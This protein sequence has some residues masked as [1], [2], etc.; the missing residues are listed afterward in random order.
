MKT[1]RKFNSCLVILMLGAVVSGL[2][3]QIPGDPTAQPPREVPLP[4]SAAGI[5]PSPDAPVRPRP[6]ERG[7]IAPG[8]FDSDF[9]AAG[10]GSPADLQSAFLQIPEPVALGRWP[11]D[12][13]ANTGSPPGEQSLIRRELR[14]GELGP[15]TAAQVTGAPNTLTMGDFSTA[16]AAA[17]ADRNEEWL[18]VQFTLEADLDRVRVVQSFNP[19][20]ITKV[21]AERSDGQ[22]VVLEEVKTSPGG[23]IPATPEAV[24]KHVRHRKQAGHPDTP[25][26]PPVVVE[27]VPPAGTSLRTTSVRITIDERKVPGWNEIDAVEIVSR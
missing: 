7:L 5:V 1:D 10:A 22:Q 17:N 19:G 24:A 6:V 21:T 3:A 15:W 26:T 8:L 4:G 13:G 12:P 20:A 23:E 2:P 25:G 16:W 14:A 9:P 18:S 27:F 11:H